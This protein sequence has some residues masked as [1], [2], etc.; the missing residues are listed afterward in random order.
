MRHVG[1]RTLVAVG[2]G[3]A[4]LAV[5]LYY[6]STVDGRAPQVSAYRLSQHLAGDET[7]A[8]TTTSLEV[9]FSEPVDRASAQGAL[10]IA[11]TV[12]GSFSWS[13]TTLV[14]T[15]TDTLPIE[16]DFTVR[17]AA[18][19]R[20]LAGN[21]M[22]QPAAPFRFRTVGRPSVVST[23]PADGDQQVALDV[24][25]T[26]TF[27]T[28]MDTGSVEQSLE[29][30]P[31]IDHQLRWSGEA[32]QIVPSQPLA[33]DQRY[34]ITLRAGA[35]DQ[36]GTRLETIFNFAFTTLAA[37]PEAVGRVPAD[38]VQGIG[39]GTQ[40]AVFFDRPIDPNSVSSD[41]LTITPSV[42]GSLQAVAPEGAAALG[43]SAAATIVRFT[44]AT[45]LPQN[46]TFEVTLAPGMRAVDG[47]AMAQALHWT[48]TTGSPPDT[49]GNQIVYI[50]SRSGVPNLWASNP[51]GSNPRQL[52][53][54]LSS[55]TGYAVAPDGRSF[56]VGDGARL[57]LYDAN[58]AHRRILTEGATL[59]FDPT[60]SPDGRRIAFGRADRATGSSLGLW[61]RSSPDG[62]DP[63]RIDLPTEPA[64]TASS[65]PTPTALAAVPL[66]RAPRY[67]PDG[68]ALAF[69]DDAGRTGILEL[70]GGRQLT[71]TDFAAV[72]PPAWLPDSSG[73][74]VSGLIAHDP[75]APSP[76]AAVPPLDAAALDLHRDELNALRIIRLTRGDPRPSETRLGGGATQPSVAADGRV[77]YLRVDETSHGAWGALYLAIS[78]DAAGT[79][80]TITPAMQVSSVT[81]TPEPDALLVARAAPQG[82]LTARGV[83]VLRVAGSAARGD[84]R[85][86]DGSAPRWL[87]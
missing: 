45:P 23:A 57:V 40:I 17:L 30:D 3:V 47:S 78:A 75:L 25:P 69:V 33:P 4:V 35:A 66:L 87:P 15:P 56:V 39:L 74:L 58:G 42:A 59:E 5:V 26:L 9:V 41:L 80:T 27:S 68:T 51:D 8:L 71:A 19:T 72:S 36:A 29:I 2:V 55:V 65:G 11:P 13:G 6:A 24:H 53:A 31:A 61:T 82:G 79:A 62:G 64:P 1:L 14:F 20:D 18:G 63:Q 48:F 77:A 76:E 43:E 16:T 70:S 22:S 21:R 73:I 67:S 7:T 84:L 85:A 52:S 37:G 50:S 54:E 46:T 49:L 10:S 86:A 12:P 38:G 34:Q 81:F 60:Y 44:P 83:W 28:L 32:L